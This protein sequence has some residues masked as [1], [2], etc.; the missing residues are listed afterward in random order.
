VLRQRLEHVNNGLDY[1]TDFAG[2]TLLWLEGTGESPAK[3]LNEHLAE[4]KDKYVMQ[5]QRTAHDAVI[6]VKAPSAAGPSLK[7]ELF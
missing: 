3:R 1:Q 7:I 4:L 2:Q 6:G 5:E